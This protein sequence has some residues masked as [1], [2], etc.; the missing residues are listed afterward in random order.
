M[1]AKT[2]SGV[3]LLTATFAA[4]GCT[5]REAKEIGVYRDVLDTGLDR[6]TLADPHGAIDVT[7]S[8]ALANVGS[9]ALA[10]EG[11]T[12]LQSII[13]RRRAAAA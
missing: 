9:E 3:L 2:R 1:N 5:P 6:S 4:F 10:I 13:D 12:Y 7:G 11:E 8:M